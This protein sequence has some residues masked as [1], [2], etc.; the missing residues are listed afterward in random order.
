MVAEK[1][2]QIVNMSGFIDTIE[3]NTNTPIDE[4]FTETSFLCT[5]RTEGELRKEHLA[6]KI[7]KDLIQQFENDIPIWENKA[8]WSRPVL[9][10]GDGPVGDYR[11]WM[12]QFF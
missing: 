2:F 5:A 1:G 12:Q 6:E 3:M 11:K 9:C 8:S 10:D 7:V 4:E